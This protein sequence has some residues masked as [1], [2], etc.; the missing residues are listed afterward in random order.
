VSFKNCKQLNLAQI[1]NASMH[2][3][4]EH[5]SKSLSISCTFSSRLA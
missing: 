1:Q 4:E 3:T 2:K 5:S